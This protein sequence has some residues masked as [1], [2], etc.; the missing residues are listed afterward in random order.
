MTN[1]LAGKGVTG[2][3]NSTNI[4]NTHGFPT[5]TTGIDVG[6]ALTTAELSTG[7][8]EAMP[9][10]TRNKAIT[11]VASTQ[12]AVTTTGAGN[13]QP[14]SPPSEGD[15]QPSPSTAGGVIGNPVAT[16]GAVAVLGAV[17]ALV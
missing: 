16:W 1:F 5:P 9:T 11:Q 12:S 13:T 15:A 6:S 2:V 10:L 8:Y 3:I 17:A 14:T 7:T 4:H